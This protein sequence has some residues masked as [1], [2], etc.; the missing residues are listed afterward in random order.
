L[1]DAATDN[2]FSH[3]AGRWYATEVSRGIDE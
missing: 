3:G 2:L 1:A